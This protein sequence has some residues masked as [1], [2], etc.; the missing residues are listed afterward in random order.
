M[1]TQEQGCCLKIRAGQHSEAGVKESNEDCCG[2]HIPDS[3]LTIRYKG[4]AA[5]IADGVSSSEAGRQAAETCVQGFLTDYYSTPDS[6]SVK[7]ASQKVLGAINRWLYG[8]G[9][10][11][12]RSGQG[13]LSTCSVVV[14]KSTTAHLFH[15]GDTRI[16][17]LRNG[18]LSALTRDHQLWQ[19]DKALLSRAMGADLQVDI[20][21]R[22]TDLEVGDLFILTTDGVH[23]YISPEDL[24][25]LCEQHG[26]DLET[27]ARTLVRTAL[28]HGSPDNATCQLIRIEALPDLDQDTFYRRLTALPFPPPL[29]PGQI[30]DGYRVIREL[31]ASHRTQ[32]YLAV[33][34]QNDDRQVV[35]KTPSVN[36]EDDA[37]YID[38]FLHEEWAGRRIDNPHV[39]KVLDPGRERSCLY[40]VT[41]YVPGQSLRQWMHDHPNPPLTDVREIV[42]QIAAGL[43][44]FHR[45]EMVHQDLKP[46][47]I[48][49]DPQGT[50]KLVDFGSTRIAGIEEIAQPVRRDYAMGTQNYLAP[51]CLQ[52]R[53]G[54]PVSDLYALGVI[55]YEMLT[56]HL[57]YDRELKP[58]N[59]KQ[60]RYRPA[61]NFNPEIPAWMDGALKKAVH[62]DPRRRYQHLSEF[63]HDLNHPNPELVKESEAPL[64]ERNP[65]AFWKGLSALLLLTNLILLALLLG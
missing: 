40:Y 59:L 64:I 35:I 50:V 41:E 43:R 6:W 53:P 56:G 32:V 11:Q 57:P 4:V 27:A 7:T 39:L 23:E 51:E 2:I 28:E 65:V 9:Q 60:V 21:Y 20:D 45:Q 26:D 52:G 55:A 34:T 38:A 24:I 12:Y 13:L 30:L 47:N 46:E 8:R 5:V 14:F 44:A 36:F 54:T 63:T 18:Q 49:I 29:S 31:H 33:D 1:N 3:A 22:T 37:E 19:G 48:L 16:Q 61:S 58:R 62:I 17:R 42:E 25:A 10:S 15:V